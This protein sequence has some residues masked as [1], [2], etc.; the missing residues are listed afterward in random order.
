MIVKWIGKGKLLFSPEY[1][2]RHVLEVVR[3][4]WA[5]QNSTGKFHQMETVRGNTDKEPKWC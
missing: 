3:E 5:T 2:R 4:T 1:K